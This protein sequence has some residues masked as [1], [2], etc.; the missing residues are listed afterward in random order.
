MLVDGEPT[1]TA[2]CYLL[3]GNSSD[4]YGQNERW[5][6]RSQTSLYCLVLVA[7]VCFSHNTAAPQDEG[8]QCYNKGV[9]SSWRSWA[10][11]YS[12]SKNVLSLLCLGRHHG[13]PTWF[14]VTDVDVQSKHNQQGD[15]GRPPVDNEH[16]HEAQDGSCQGYPHIVVLEAR[17]PPCREKN[18]NLAQF[19]NI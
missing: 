17:T 2:N 3:Y 10:F 15:Q 14:L 16:D 4:H 9:R 7:P 13:A 19:K 11:I 1:E 5:T 12:G 18:S 6:G 8:F